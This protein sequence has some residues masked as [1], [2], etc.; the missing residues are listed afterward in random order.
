V[1]VAKSQRDRQMTNSI[2]LRDLPDIPP[3]PDDSFSSLLDKSCVTRKSVKICRACSTKKEK[4]L[5]LQV[6]PTCAS[7]MHAEVSNPLPR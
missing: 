7:G 5:A 3:N 2:D 6:D 1:I 4:P